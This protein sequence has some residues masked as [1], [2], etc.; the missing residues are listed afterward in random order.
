MR[1]NDKKSS[2]TGSCPKWVRVSG[3]VCVVHCVSCV[4]CAVL[5]CVV[6][7]LGGRCWAL[8]WSVSTRTARNLLLTWNGKRVCIFES[9]L[10]M[11]PRSLV[12]FAFSRSLSLSLGFARFLSLYLVFSCL[13]RFF[14]LTFSCF[15]AF[16][17]LCLFTWFVFGRFC[18]PFSGR[19]L[20]RLIGV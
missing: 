8:F 17:V 13:S 9:F 19:F 16:S 11:C 4:C 6:V 18:G 15:L 7:C 14:V 12:S 20:T 10:V 5:C 2:R 1:K 3:F